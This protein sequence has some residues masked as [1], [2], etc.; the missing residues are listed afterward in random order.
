MKSLAVLSLLLF[1][2][3]THAFVFPADLKA[4]HYEMKCNTFN[5]VHQAPSKPFHVVSK[6]D[7]TTNDGV[8]F[9]IK[10]TATYNGYEVSLDQDVVRKVKEVG[11]SKSIIYL[12]SFSFTPNKSAQVLQ[13]STQA[14]GE[15]KGIISSIASDS[16]FVTTT[17]NST[18]NYSE[19]KLSPIKTKVEINSG[20]RQTL[21]IS[22]DANKDLR[23]VDFGTSLVSE[24]TKCEIV[25]SL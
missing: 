2:A 6:F 5:Q 24:K 13:L 10:G 20:F 1:S 14:N 15:L 7:V 11:S 19:E 8:K 23:D 18:A 21:A 16:K 17:N 9:G 12:S 3:H 22:L 25:Y 4:G